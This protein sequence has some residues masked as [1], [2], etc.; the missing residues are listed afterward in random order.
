MEHIQIYNKQQTCN[1][2]VLQVHR[3]DEDDDHDDHG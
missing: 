2:N 1:E 3:N